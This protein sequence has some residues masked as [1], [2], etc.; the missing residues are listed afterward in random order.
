MKGIHITPEM[1]AEWENEKEKIE[2]EIRRRVERLELINRKL[3]AVEALSPPSDEDETQ[4][5]GTGEIP[6]TNGK[7]G[8]SLP[9]VSL[10]GAV[11]GILETGAMNAKQIR[12]TLEA[13]NFPA[14]KFGTN[15]AYFYT[16][17]KRLVNRKAI[18]RRGGK[19]R[20]NPK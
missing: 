19:Y 13:N 16:V 2:S 17:L 1:V 14:Q 9:E 8:A 15:N 11:R 5:G 3:K 10:P 12:E 20:L 6:E 7:E 18:N 4:V